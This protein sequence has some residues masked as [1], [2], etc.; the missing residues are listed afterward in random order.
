MLDVLHQWICLNDL[1]NLMEISLANF[2]FVFE[3]LAEHRKLFRI[4][5]L[6]LCKR[7]GELI[8]TRFSY[9][10]SMCYIYMLMD[11]Y[12]QVLQ[13]NGKL[14]YNFRIIIRIYYIFYGGGICADLHAF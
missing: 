5:M 8:S 2:E 4:T 12:R 11:S 14:F 3:L 1:Y 7:G 13:T 10:S 6:G 9:Q